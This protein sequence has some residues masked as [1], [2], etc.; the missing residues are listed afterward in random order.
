MKDA[1]GLT[2]SGTS[3]AGLAAYQRALDACKCF[4]GDPAGLTEQ[5]LA[6]SP[7]MTMAHVVKAWLYLLG[8]EPAGT[9]VGRAACD[10]AEA[11]P[12]NERE[13]MHLQAA[14]L[15]A[16]GHWYEAGRVLEDLSVLYPRDLLALQAG[17]QVDFFTGDSRM[18][19][20]SKRGA[21]RRAASTRRRLPARR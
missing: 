17:H 15:V 3:A 6:A 8:T 14:R 18:R 12:A 1:L 19:D 16:H 7:G 10:A 20:R 21:G 11:L 2:L 5:A 13:R 9:A 4:R